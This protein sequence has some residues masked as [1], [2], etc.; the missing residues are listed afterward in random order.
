MT[1][2]RKCVSFK[3]QLLHYFLF[4]EVEEGEAKD[5]ASVIDTFVPN[6][7]IMPIQAL[8]QAIKLK[9]LTF[10]HRFYELPPV[11]PPVD[12]QERKNNW[13]LRVEFKY[14]RTFKYAMSY[15][16]SYDSNRKECYTNTNKYITYKRKEPLDEKAFYFLRDLILTNMHHIKIGCMN[17]IFGHYW[18]YCGN[19]CIEGHNECKH[20]VENRLTQYFNEI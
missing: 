7:H 11:L 19:K 3:D 6:P 1:K 9:K 4:N 10:I 14:G 20:C 15:Y 2:K 18:Q 17:K 12:G 16:N 5:I 8:K 13:V